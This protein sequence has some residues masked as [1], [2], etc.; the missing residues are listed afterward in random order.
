MPNLAVAWSLSRPAGKD[1]PQPMATPW[2]SPNRGVEPCKGAPYRYRNAI[3]RTFRVL[4]QGVFIDVGFDAAPT[5]GSL[6]RSWVQIRATAMPIF[7][8]FTID[9][10]VAVKA[11]LPFFAPSFSAEGHS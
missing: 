7:Q 3:E 4:F 1:H 9:D 8:R 10:I 11:F 2:E 6:R 5:S